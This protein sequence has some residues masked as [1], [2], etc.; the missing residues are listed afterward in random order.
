M[1]SGARNILFLLLSA[2]ALC[3]GQ[4]WDLD[5]LL[6]EMAEVPASRT[7]FVEIRQLALLT[8]PVELK[9]SLSYERPHHLAKHV[10]SPFDELLTVNGDALTLLNRTKGE[11]RFLSLREQPALRALVE[12]I[13]ATL[14]G[15]RAQLERH[16]RME[17]S[18]PRGAWR[19]RLV[20]RDA[21]LRAYVES[22]TLSGAG[23]RVQRIEALEASGDS[24][25]M[26]ILHDGK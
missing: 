10:E 5:A 12:S 13:R 18:G 20:P 8:R 4:S 2:P 7:R 22:V 23:A 14:A 26:T 9:G 11:Q 3:F 1:I 17:F 24:S 6:R 25:V 15:D 21:Q 16:Y 19:L